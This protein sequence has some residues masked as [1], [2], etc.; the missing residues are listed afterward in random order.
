MNFDTL[1]E[2]A[3][4]RIETLTNQMIYHH[5]RN[6]LVNLVLV[7]EEIQDL[8]AALDSDDASDNF[9]F[10]PYCGVN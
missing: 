9:F 10:A 7:K 4:D 5:S 6:D 8:T 2:L 3:I 1:T